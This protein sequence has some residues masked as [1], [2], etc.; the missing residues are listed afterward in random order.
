VRV[1]TTFV[2]LH[3]VDL[4]AAVALAAGLL[5]FGLASVRLPQAVEE[6]YGDYTR[7]TAFHLLPLLLAP[8]VGLVLTGAVPELERQA[9]RSL[10]VPRGALLI[11]CTA[12]ALVTLLPASTVVDVDHAVQ[13]SAE[14]TLCV[15][16]AMAILTGWLDRTWAWFPVVAVGAVGLVSADHSTVSTVAILDRTPGDTTICLVIWALGLVVYTFK[17]AHRRT[18][19]KL[20][21]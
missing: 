8:V 21:D 6:G 12:I 19:E 16:G 5:G 17:G 20:V 1:A 4:F 13:V 3:G 11:G 10:L 18:Q 15:I 9:S 14:N 7:L 2:R